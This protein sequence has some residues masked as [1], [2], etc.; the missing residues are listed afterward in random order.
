MSN[1]GS[2]L[3]INTKKNQVPSNIRIDDHVRLHFVFPGFSEKQEFIGLVKNIRK[4]Q[5]EIRIGIKFI[6]LQDDMRERIEQYLG[7]IKS[8]TT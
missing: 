8:L 6:Q 3:Q 4:D 2:L 1:Q 7:S 5:E